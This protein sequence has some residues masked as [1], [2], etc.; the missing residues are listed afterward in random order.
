[1]HNP[2]YPDMHASAVTPLELNDD[3]KVPDKPASGEV[4]IG[5][6]LPI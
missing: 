4:C 1:M 5:F 2:F 3:S 6:G